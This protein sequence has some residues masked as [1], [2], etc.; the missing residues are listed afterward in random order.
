MEHMV[1][2]NVMN[3]NEDEREVEV[4][5]ELDDFYNC[6]EDDEKIEF[7]CNKTKD[8]YKN[9]EQ[10]LFD[11]SNL[12]ELENELDDMNDLSDMIPNEDFD[13]YMEHENWD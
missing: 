9:V 6:M 1:V 4:Y 11:E 7:I 5:F 8:Q 12:I 2:V 13:E 10:I 3:G